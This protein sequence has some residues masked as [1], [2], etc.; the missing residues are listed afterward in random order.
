M[1]AGKLKYSEKHLFQCH[2]V[3]YKLQVDWHG[4]ELGHMF[5]MLES[6]I[7]LLRIVTVLT[8]WIVTVNVPEMLHPADIPLLFGVLSTC[9]FQF[10]VFS[11]CAVLFGICSLKFLF[12]SWFVLSYH[13]LFIIT[14]HQM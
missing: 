6:S 12:F 13:L 3:H 1:L 14:W 2:F 9:C 4:I 11:L 8:S 5:Q 7:F 10:R